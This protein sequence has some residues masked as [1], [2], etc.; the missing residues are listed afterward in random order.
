M[1]KDLQ[2]LFPEH[3]DKNVDVSEMSAP[4]RVERAATVRAMLNSRGFEILNEYVLALV[5]SLQY[6]MSSAKPEEIPNIQGRIEG[7]KAYQNAAALVLEDGD[8]AKAELEED[9]KAR[10]EEELDGHPT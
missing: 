4:M 5:S 3:V 10:K 8:L 1:H 2:K 6:S 7:V 9:A